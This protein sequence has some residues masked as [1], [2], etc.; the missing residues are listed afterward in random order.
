MDAELLINN[1]NIGQSFCGN[2]RNK[3]I[4]VMSGN[5][6]TVFYINNIEVASLGLVKTL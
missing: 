4:R 1:L 2:V 3:Q 6:N 5:S